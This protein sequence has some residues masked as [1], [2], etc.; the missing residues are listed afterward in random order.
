MKSKPV[1]LLLA[2]IASFAFL[3]SCATKP[4]GA[5]SHQSQSGGDK[6]RQADLI[7]PAHVVRQWKDHVVLQLEQADPDLR[8]PFLLKE[9]DPTRKLREVNLA[10]P[11]E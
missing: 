6:A 10:Q 2:I 4:G 1:L 9:Y 5:E 8:D 11:I 3:P 7:I